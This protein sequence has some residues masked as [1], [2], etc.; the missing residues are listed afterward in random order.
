M[1]YLF[2]GHQDKITRLDQ[3]DQS[4]ETPRTHANHLN[5]QSERRYI[6][7][8]LYGDQGFAVRHRINIPASTHQICVEKRHRI[9]TIFCNEIQFI[10]DTLRTTILANLSNFIAEFV[11]NPTI[12]FIGKPQFPFVRLMN[13]MIQIVFMPR[14]IIIEPIQRPNLLNHIDGIRF[15]ERNHPSA[16]FCD[17]S[18]P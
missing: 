7:K 1:R 14:V 17:T 9:M 13:H 11:G 6:R 8:F 3:T 4:A 12:R 18:A 5:E 2:V 15:C 10:D 16:I